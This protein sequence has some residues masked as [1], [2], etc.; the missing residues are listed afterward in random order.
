MV[1]QNVDGL[2]TRAAHEAAGRAD[3]S[4]ALP[5]EVH[6]TIDRDKCSACGVRTPGMTSV[7]ASSHGSLPR[8]TACDGMLRP[9]VVWFGEPLEPE[10]L[11][12]VFQV[13]RDADLCLV[14][15]TSSLVQPA[16]SVPL[17]TQH[18]GGMLIE[19]NLEPTPLSGEA[20]VSLLGPAGEL[21]PE[22]LDLEPVT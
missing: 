22:L 21:L 6:G 1:T 11:S 3:P 16:A 7:D 4:P 8:C 17:V 15:G 19:V 9:D 18:S 14:V 20:E 2:H 5:V 12:H 10:V 13:A